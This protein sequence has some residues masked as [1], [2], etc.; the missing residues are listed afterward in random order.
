MSWAADDQDGNGLHLGKMRL[1]FSSLS[2]LSWKLAKTLIIYFFC[3]GKFTC[4]LPL[5]VL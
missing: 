2:L 4:H 1:I 3:L 5:G